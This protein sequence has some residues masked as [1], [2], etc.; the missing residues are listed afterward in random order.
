MQG[1]IGTTAVMLLLQTIAQRD[2][3]LSDEIRFKS[4]AVPEQKRQGGDLELTYFH[5]SPPFWSLYLATGTSVAGVIHAR[6]LKQWIRKQ[7][8]EACAVRR[9]VQ[10]INIS[11]AGIGG[12]T[13]D[14]E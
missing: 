13:M 5:A 1:T 12:C 2:G 10:E 6:S 7:Y 3:H 4:D 14:E 8:A 11:Q 9:G